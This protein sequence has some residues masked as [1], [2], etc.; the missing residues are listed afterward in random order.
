MSPSAKHYAM[1]KP[2]V[3]QAVVLDAVERAQQTHGQPVRTR[4][5]WPERVKAWAQLARQVAELPADT[6]GRRLVMITRPKGRAREWA[7][8]RG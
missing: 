7:V 1:T 5:V 3:M 6:L 8:L 2:A 4:Q